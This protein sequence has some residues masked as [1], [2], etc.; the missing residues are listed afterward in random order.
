META[1]CTQP[2]RTVRIFDQS[3]PLG[4]IALFG[5]Q[6]KRHDAMATVAFEP[7]Y[8]PPSL[9]LQTGQ[10]VHKAIRTLALY[11]DG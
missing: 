6:F 8:M 7:R 5:M 3:C 1:W 2:N 11:D 4:R 9:D 10:R